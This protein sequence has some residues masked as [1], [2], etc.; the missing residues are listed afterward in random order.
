MRA[1]EP[2]GTPKRPWEPQNDPATIGP[3][4]G[5]EQGGNEEGTRRSRGGSKETLVGGSRPGGR[6]NGLDYS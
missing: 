1:V 3:G 6:R 4:A 2:L 5:R